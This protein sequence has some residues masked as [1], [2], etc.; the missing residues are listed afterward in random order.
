MYLFKTIIGVSIGL[1][2]SQT[3]VY[4]IFNIIFISVTNQGDGLT[5]NVWKAPHLILAEQENS[6]K[7][8]E[9]KKERKIPIFS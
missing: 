5:T 2:Q 3:D 4:I 9:V 7:L 8:P 1:I 6:Q